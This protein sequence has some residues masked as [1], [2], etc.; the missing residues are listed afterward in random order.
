M[1]TAIIGAGGFVGRAIVERLRADGHDV[2]PIVRAPIGLSGEQ[3]INDLVTAD[4]AALLR[5]VDAVILTAARVHMMDDRAA[6]PLAAFRLVNR[7]GAVAAYRGAVEAGVR[8]FVF[9]SSVKVNGEAT[10]PSRPFTADDPPAPEDP[11]GVSKYEAE[12]ELTALAAAGG[13][14][15]VIVRP[16]LVYGPGVRANFGAMMKW[17]GRGIPLPLGAVTGNRRGL[18]GLDNLVD[19]IVLCLTHPK[20]AGETFLVSDGRDVSTTELLRLLGS[21]LGK[22]AR[23][24]PVPPAA[25]RGL[26]RL[27][28]KGSALQRL[29]GSLQVDIGKNREMLGWTPPVSLEEGLRRAAAAKR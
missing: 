28:G 1:K 11:Y 20:A 6:D 21:V 4:L 7:D 9:V 18:V 22:P 17:L 8:R 19:F 23:L 10:Q 14:E 27:T 2:L 24:L 16:P 5:G 26:G 29:T 13:P 15:L 12:Q 3:A 25:L